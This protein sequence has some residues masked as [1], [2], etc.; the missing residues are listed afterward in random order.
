MSADL[1]LQTRAGEPFVGY[2]DE[3][4]NKIHFHLNEKNDSDKVNS[5]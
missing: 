2:Y 4:K 5:D 1:G 3:L